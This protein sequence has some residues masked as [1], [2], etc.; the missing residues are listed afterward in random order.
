MWLRLEK[1]TDYCA[2]I[3]LI[4][5]LIHIDVPAQL[6]FICELSHG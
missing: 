3:V 4:N 5:F 6:D 1:N 2:E